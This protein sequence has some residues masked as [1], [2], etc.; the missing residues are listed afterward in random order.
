MMYVVLQKAEIEVQAHPRL[1]RGK[2]QWV[3]RYLR[4]GEFAEPRF[5]DVI[6]VVDEY[7]IKQHK[8]DIEDYVDFATQR[9]ANK[10]KVVVS[11]AKELVGE[12]GDYLD[13]MTVT[14]NLYSKEKLKGVSHTWF[15]PG[16]QAEIIIQFNFAQNRIY[17]NSV[18]LDEKLQGKGVGTDIV[19]HAIE[20]GLKKGMSEVTLGADGDTGVYSW[21]RMGFDWVSDSGTQAGVANIKQVQAL[22]DGFRQYVM[23]KYHKLV[24]PQEIQHSWQ[25]ANYQVDGK[26]VGKEYMLGPGHSIFYH[27]KM[28]L[29]AY[30][31]WKQSKGLA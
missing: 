3:H 31:A 6:P 8:E 7:G 16:E 30:R 24:P 21:A 18:F 13:E 23:K 26:R 10:F 22:K 14:L 12:P 5:R 11:Q 4:E 15:Y 19:H 9:W 29:D 25:I 27:A 2:Y 17:I 20:Y 1:V 28:D